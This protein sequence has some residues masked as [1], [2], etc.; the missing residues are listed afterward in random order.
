MMNNQLETGFNTSGSIVANDDRRVRL[1]SSATGMM[2]AS[3]QHNLKSPLAPPSSKY[4]PPGKN[5]IVNFARYFEKYLTAL[6]EIS[7]A[8]RDSTQ[9]DTII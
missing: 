1:S 5:V 8:S 7:T 4:S 3:T 2:Q 9:G 6:S